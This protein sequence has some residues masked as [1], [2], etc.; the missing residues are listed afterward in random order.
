MGEVE[1]YC[2]HLERNLGM[3]KRVMQ[4]FTICMT[5]FYW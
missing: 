3:K 5:R 2:R 1:I 4:I